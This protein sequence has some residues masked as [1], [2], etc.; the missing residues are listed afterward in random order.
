MMKPL[1][2]LS[3]PEYA[4]TLTPSGDRYHLRIRSFDFRLHFERLSATADFFD[5]F[6]VKIIR[7]FDVPFFLLPLKIFLYA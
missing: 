6:D 7:L 4:I 1:L 5:K 2:V 3:E